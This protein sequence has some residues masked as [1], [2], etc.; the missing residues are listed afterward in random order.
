MEKNWVL[1]RKR[2]RKFWHYLLPLPKY[3]KALFAHLGKNVKIDFTV[4]IDGAEH[5]HVGDRVKVF[6][7][8]WLNIVK[9]SDKEDEKGV[10]IR[11]GDGTVISRRVIISASRFVV[12]GKDVMIAP[13]TMILDTDHAYENIQVPIAHQGFSCKGG[14]EIGDGCWIAYGAVILGGVSVG[15]QSVVGANSVITKDI[16]PFS[17]AVGNPARVIKTYDFSRKEWM[18]V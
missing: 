3:R 12:I 7:Y 5:M 9:T 16:P 13:N 4:E 10:K 8:C 6:P 2:W 14:I 17:V 15:K 11:V 18:R 1:V